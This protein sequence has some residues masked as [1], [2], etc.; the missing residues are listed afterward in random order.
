PDKGVCGQFAR[1][2]L[3]LCFMGCRSLTAES[4]LAACSGIF[5]AAGWLDPYAISGSCVVGGPSKREI[6]GSVWAR[7][8]HSCWSFVAGERSVPFLYTLE[9][10]RNLF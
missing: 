9:F 4:L 10:D 6:V 1:D 5:P 2:S 8:V 7:A 3:Q